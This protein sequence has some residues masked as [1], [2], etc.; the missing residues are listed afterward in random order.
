MGEKR[1]TAKAKAEAKFK[2]VGTK[3]NEESLS[4]FNEVWTAQGFRSASAYIKHL[5]EVD[6]VKPVGEL[7]RENEEQRDELELLRVQVEELR[8]KD[9]LLGKF[10]N[11][12]KEKTGQ[13]KE[14]IAY[15]N[16]YHSNEEKSEETAQSEENKAESLIS[17]IL[18]WFRR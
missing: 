12:S 10:L 3:L 13:I 14:L 15:L 1:Q 4:L 17:R 8:A 9:A 6:R 5:I 18:G 7:I 16:E 2:M 11:D